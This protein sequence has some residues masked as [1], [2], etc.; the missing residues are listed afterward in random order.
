MTINSSQLK[1]T[2]RSTY[3]NSTTYNTNDMVLYSGSAWIYRNATSAAG[4]APGTASADSTAYWYRVTK[5]SDL[6][7]LTLGTGSLGRI[8]A[9]TLA[10]SSSIGNMVV[11]TDFEVGKAIKVEGN[12]SAS[13]YVSATEL[14][15]DYDALP[16]SDP[17]IKGQVYRNGSNQLFISAG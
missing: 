16:S 5:G 6:G 11:G 3:D 9:T 8:E 2:W 17:G 1:T 7:A 14:I 13:G 4:N 10:V 12:V 15:L